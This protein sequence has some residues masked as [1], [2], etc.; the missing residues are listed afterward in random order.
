MTNFHIKTFIG[1]IN[2]QPI[3]LVNARELHQK[4]ENGKQFSDWIQHR[5]SKYGFTENL[6]FIGVHQ[7]VNVESGFF[8]LRQKEIK[9]Y[10]ITL[11]M[12]KELCMLERSELGQKARRYFIQMEKEALQARQLPQVLPAKNTV[13]ISTDKY[14][15]LLET[16]NQLLKQ[17]VKPQ[18]Y[19]LRL[20]ADEKRHILS[21]HQQGLTTG[22]IVQQ[23]GRSESAVRTVIRG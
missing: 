21:L 23:T 1:Q 18:R 6:D 8:G 11:D 7:I 10:H 5:I 13:E 12:A 14:I 4:L 2:N 20:T 16:Q 9:E 19:K 3:Q 22:Q 17:V 15:E